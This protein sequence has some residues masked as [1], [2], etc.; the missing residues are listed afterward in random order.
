MDVVYEEV[1]ER[2]VLFL[3]SP[4][5]CVS[6]ILTLILLLL[7]STWRFEPG[8]EDVGFKSN[9]G[10]NVE[11]QLYHP[12]FRVRAQT[13]AVG[14]GDLDHQIGKTGR[15]CI[16]LNK[17]LLFTF[18]QRCKEQDGLLDDPL[19]VRRRG[20]L[21]DGQIQLL[22]RGEGNTWVGQWSASLI[23]EDVG[24]LL[25]SDLDFLGGVVVFR[26]VGRVA[27][28]LLGASQPVAIHGRSC[29]KLYHTSN[30]PYSFS[31]RRRRL[32]GSLAASRLEFSAKGVFAISL[33][34]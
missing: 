31:K 29:G 20:D 9:L 19:V 3:R 8:R 5:K 24:Q 13:D 34:H 33:D 10:G 7:S 21:G 14:A 25:K 16:A 27:P 26:E 12:S 11:G 2:K 28:C 32:T 1:E 30:W 4:F 15:E 23:A 18:D 17:G 22:S 6:T